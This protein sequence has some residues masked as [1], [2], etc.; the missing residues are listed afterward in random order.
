MNI[1]FPVTAALVGA[2]AIDLLPHPGWLIG[3]TIM[4]TDTAD[5]YALFY[6]KPASEVTVGVTTPYFYLVLF[7]QT[8]SPVTRAGEGLAFLRAISVACVNTVVA[9]AVVAR[10]SNVALIVQ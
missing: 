7:G 6:D 8:P 9:G 4:N 1:G 3:G 10:L 2:T 5:G